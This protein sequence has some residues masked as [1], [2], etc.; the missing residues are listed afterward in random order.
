MQ[1]YFHIRKDYSTSRKLGAMNKDRVLDSHFILV[2]PNSTMSLM[3]IADSNNN[4]SFDSPSVISY[5][6]FLLKKFISDI[7]EDI[8]SEIGVDLMKSVRPVLETM[9]A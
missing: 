3:L 9:L 7:P 8:L 2:D 1:K 4:P 6:L 5:K